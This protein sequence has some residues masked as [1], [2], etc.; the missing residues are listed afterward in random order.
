MLLSF[1]CATLYTLGAFLYY[2]HQLT[3]LYLKEVENYSEAKVR[4]NTIIWPLRVMEHVVESIMF[5]VEDDQEDD[6]K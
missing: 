6:T 2:L 4:L 1:I 5:L 3:I